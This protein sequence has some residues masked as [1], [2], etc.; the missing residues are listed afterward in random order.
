MMTL[1]FCAHKHSCTQLD[2]CNNQLLCQNPRNSPNVLSISAFP[3][4]TFDKR[5]HLN[6]LSD[7]RVPDATY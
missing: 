1:I 4:M 7:T 3:Y 2:N 5:H 6:N